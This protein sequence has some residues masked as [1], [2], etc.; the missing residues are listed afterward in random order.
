[1]PS[2][3]FNLRMLFNL[4][5]SMG[6]F[7][8]VVADDLIF[9]DEKYAELYEIDM[10]AMAAGIPVELILSRIAQ[11][12]RERLA[13]RI[14]SVLLGGEPFVSSYDIVCPSG[15]RKSLVSMG[16]CSRDETDTAF[17]YSGAVLLASSATVVADA[18]DLE[19]HI[20]AALAL[21]RTEGHE[22]TERYLSS[23]L[24]SVLL[25]SR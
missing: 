3:V 12:D 25:S 11:E 5:P 13:S 16:S 9:A 14:H 7:S 10:P 24:G 1:M 20:S 21:A 17:I 8:W 6:F 23:A 2:E 4:M 15:Q 18:S 19:A 22:I